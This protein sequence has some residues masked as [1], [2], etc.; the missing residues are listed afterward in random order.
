MSLGLCHPD[1]GAMI[2]R[3]GGDDIDIDTDISVGR[4]ARSRRAHYRHGWFCA[5]TRRY[6]R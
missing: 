3:L 2:K 6:G 1:V 5:R 4:A